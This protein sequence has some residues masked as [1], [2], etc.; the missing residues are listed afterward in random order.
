[1]S[2]QQTVFGAI[3]SFLK[4]LHK[5]ISNI[6]FNKKPENTKTVYKCVGLYIKHVF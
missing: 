2:F 5:A 3:S 4:K 6:I 1:M